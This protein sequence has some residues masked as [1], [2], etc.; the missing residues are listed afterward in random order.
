MPIPEERI[1]PKV[2]KAIG[3]VCEAAAR[4]ELRRTRNPADRRWLRFVLDLAKLRKE[5]RSEA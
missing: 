4:A 2:G 1:D 3:D 5:T